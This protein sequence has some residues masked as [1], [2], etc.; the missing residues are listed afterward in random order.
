PTQ[1][2]LSG[3]TKG[4]NLARKKRFQHGSLFKRGRRNKKWVWRWWEQV[5][6]SEGK[7][8]AVR[9]SEILG[10][11]AELPTPRQA[12]QLLAQRMQKINGDYQSA[13]ST[14]NFVDFVR[15]DWEPV[16]SADDEIR[17]AKIVCLFSSGALDPSLRRSPAAGA[18]AGEDSG[19]AARQAGIRTA[20][21]NCAPHSSCAQENTGYGS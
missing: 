3:P 9:R 6:D 18:F 19:A 4:G 1:N 7:S 21:G 5:I 13:R 12:E 16:N 10:T 15:N 14:R 17:Y 20:L 8:R 11:V 2:R